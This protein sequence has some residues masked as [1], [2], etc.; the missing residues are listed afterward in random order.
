M[1]AERIR[2]PAAVMLL[3][4]ISPLLGAEFAGPYEQQVGDNV[5]LLKSTEPG[6]R[7]AAAE[8]LGMLR[9]YSAESALMDGL[10]DASA[11]VR[12]QSALAL[13]WCGSR[14]AVVP[15]LAALGDE[16]WTAR[17]AAHVALMNI[18]G[19][20]FPYDAL[21]TPDT[22]L[23]QE[24]VWS[25]W[26][27]TVP[28]ERPP[29]EVLDLLPLGAAA[30]AV[31]AVTVSSTYKGPPEVLVD[32]QLGPEYWQTKNVKP[33]QWCCLDLGEPRD[34]HQVTVHQYGAG[35]CLTE[36][37]LAVSIDG[38]TYETVERHTGTTSPKLIIQ[39]PARKTRYVRITSFGAERSL[40]PTTFYEIE[41]N[42]VA[43]AGSAADTDAA[44][45]AERGLRALGA[46]GGDGSAAAIVRVLGEVPRS[47]PNWR[48]AQPRGAAPLGR[49][50]GDDAFDYLVRLLDNTT[51]ARYAA[52]ALGD[53]GDPRDSAAARRLRS[54]C[55]EAGRQGPAWC[56]G[57]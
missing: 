33:P 41:L 44:W 3:L 43:P 31:R 48:V 14:R 45:Q 51:W 49:L 57:G 25:D 28:E 6:K 34:V 23:R 52:D 7:G 21:A 22:R 8:R 19:M 5:L 32:G 26:W 11:E 24:R 40:Y 56:P 36:Y 46:L 53:L 39:F 2:Y 18:T 27:Q 55:Q 16:E 1:P 35:Y 13:A 54:L 4:G 15:L 37:E 29:R 20:A 12:R 47:L 38:V 9:A 30:P 42:G 17:Q 10:Q 50:G